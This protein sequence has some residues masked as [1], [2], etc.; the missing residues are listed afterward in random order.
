[1]L[2]ERLLISLDSGAQHAVPLS[3]T[4]PLMM[5]PMG[6]RVCVSTVCCGFHR[7]EHLTCWLHVQEDAT[8]HIAAVLD[9]IKPEYL[10]CAP[11]YILFAMRRGCCLLEALSESHCEQ[12]C[13]VKDHG[14]CNT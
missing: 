13:V 6:S 7:S 10:V 1:M 5:L 11:L 3:V 9:R 2:Y 12:Q 8:E 4:H 14:R